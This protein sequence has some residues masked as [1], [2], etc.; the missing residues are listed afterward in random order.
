MKQKRFILILL[1]ISFSL[2]QLNPEAKHQ[3]STRWVNAALDQLHYKDQKLNDDFSLVIFNQYLK[4]LDYNKAFFLQS[5]IA[6]FSKFKYQMDD[7]L[8]VGNVNTA[9]FIFNRFMH[10]INQRFTNV[11]ELIESD[12][13]FSLDEEFFY[14]RETAPW[15]SAQKELNDYWRKRIKNEL[16]NLM[17]SGKDLKKSRELIKQ[18]YK[19]QERQF[20]QFKN[21]DVY[22]F[23]MNAYLNSVDP[24]TTYF[25]PRAAENFN[26]G[27]K[28]SLE[29]IGAQLRTV[30][31]YTTVHRIIKAGPADK[32]GELKSKDKIIGVAQDSE[33]F[34]DVIGWRIDDVVKLIRGKKGTL[35]RLKVIP[36]DA[37][38]SETVEISIIRDQV[39][40]E[41][42]A[43]QASIQ[44]VKKDGKDFRLGVIDLPTFYSNFAAQ[45]PDDPTF[46][47]STTDV[48]NLL[49]S[50]KAEG[51]D[52]VLMDLRN[53]GGGSLQ[54]AVALTGLFIEDGPVVQVKDKKNQI[55]VLKD[56]DKKIIYDGPL[57][58]LI[59]QSSASASEIFAGA[60]QDYQRGLVIGMQSFGKGTVQRVLDLGR[61]IKSKEVGQVKLTTSKFYRVSGESTQHQGVIPDIVYPT[62]YTH[63]EYGESSLDHALTWDKIKEAKHKKVGFGGKNLEPVFQNHEKRVKKSVMFQQLKK[64][65]ESAKENSNTKS[66]TL[67]EKKRRLEME[68]DK[69]KR[70]LFVNERRKAQG[71][72]EIKK[73]EKFPKEKA[74]DFILKESQ[75]ILLDLI[76]VVK[77]A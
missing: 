56:E 37:D 46:R 14:D 24:H 9:F 70:R 62:R 33:D 38:A 2:S 8:K 65:I 7:D 32:Q 28:L 51:V 48:H 29:G 39:K 74:N 11:F 20:N 76:S 71:L 58:V 72:P 54:E 16:L 6:E 61:Y 26:I 3:I 17:V 35:V 40:L 66:V 60:I 13:D 1:L 75:N 44:L 23:F 10:R 53:N 64:S 63:E 67:N 73:G 12:F 36:K 42:Q 25:S 22:Q 45:N 55:D 41:D 30:N 31:E 59:N 5:D 57:V 15:A 49:D 21:E 18:R 4:D 50:L 43:A 69:E 19:N 68:V 77:D 27:M 47:S 52:G 34:V